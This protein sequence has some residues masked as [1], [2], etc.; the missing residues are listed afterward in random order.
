MPTELE[1]VAMLRDLRAA[2]GDG[3]HSMEKAA[4]DA[5]IAALRPRGNPAFVGEWHAKAVSLGYD[6][7]ADMLDSVERGEP[8]QHIATALA[9]AAGAKAQQPGAQAVAEVVQR[10]PYLDGSPNPCRSLKWNHAV[11]PSCEDSLPVGTKLYTQPPSIPEPSDEAVNAL[12]R[13]ISEVFALHWDTNAYELR[14]VSRAAL[15]TYTARLRERIG[16]C[17]G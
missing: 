11:C 17:N 14:R 1:H 6:G 13:K 8:P 9:S 10:E 12:A 2:Y 15:T 7:V 5:A 16:G 3:G 4:L